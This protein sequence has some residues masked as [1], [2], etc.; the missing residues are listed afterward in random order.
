MKPK[1]R[2]KKVQVLTIAADR[3]TARRLNPEATTEAID[4]FAAIR[5]VTR[6]VARNEKSTIR[7]LEMITAQVPEP[8]L[9]AWFNQRLKVAA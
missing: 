5:A 7:A 6:S 1:L 4:A 8:T 9:K 3:E 2:N